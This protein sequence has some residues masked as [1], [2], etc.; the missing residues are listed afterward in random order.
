MSKMCF[1]GVLKRVT[2]FLHVFMH[3]AIKPHNICTTELSSLMVLEC[4][5][6]NYCIGNS[7]QKSKK[8]KFDLLSLTFHSV[9]D[10]ALI[11]IYLTNCEPFSIILIL[12]CLHLGMAKK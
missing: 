6:P 8:Q 2:E 9:F 5:F 4:A 12:V 1:R 3:S 11:C 10:I 7:W